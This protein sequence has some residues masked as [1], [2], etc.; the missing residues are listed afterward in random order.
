T[1]LIAKVMMN[2]STLPFV[3]SDLEIDMLGDAYEYLIGQFAASSGKKAGEFYT[4]QQV[5]TILAKI[6]TDGKED[7]RSVY[8]PTCGS[9]SL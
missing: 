8:D 5:S 7:L 9:G 3:H 4:P 2:I 1:K 6:V